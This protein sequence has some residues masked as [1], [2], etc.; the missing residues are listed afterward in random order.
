M[1]IVR[2]IITICA[3]AFVCIFLPFLIIK[4]SF[5]IDAINANELISRFFTWRVIGVF[6]FLG[7]TLSLWTV[8]IQVKQGLG[9]P[10]PVMPPKK[11]LISGPY[12]FCRNPMVFGG[13]IY[14]LGICIFTESMDA[15][16]PVIIAFIILLFWI[17][18]LEEPQLEEN[19]G[20]AYKEYKQQTPF[21]IP[22]ILGKRWYFLFLR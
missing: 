12:T 19:F 5:F 14:F 6:G 11:L 9:T 18:T 15:F 3:A 20:Q 2:V 8:Y 13:L 10:I 16:R 1:W 17:K 21:M 4:H 7:L 22:R